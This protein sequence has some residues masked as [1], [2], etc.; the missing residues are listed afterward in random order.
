MLT[1]VQLVIGLTILL[2]GGDCLVRGS[3]RIASAFGMSQLL[4]GMTIVSLGTS[5][6]E[7]AVCLDAVLHGTSEIALGNIVGSNISNIL[8]ILG[9]T[10]LFYPITVSHRIIRVEVPVM[11]GFSFLFLIL[12]FDGR[13]SMLDGAGLVFCMLLF[14]AAQIRSEIR[15]QK[16]SNDE[17]SDAKVDTA[18]KSWKA[19]ASSLS[20]MLAGIVMLWLGADWM[21][22]A[23][24]DI[25][26]AW[27][28]SEL[29]IG[30]TI[31]AIGSSAP[32]LITTVSAVKQG[33]AEMAL[34]NVLGSNIANL[35]TVGGLS[36]I[37]GGGIGVPSSLFQLDLPVMLAAAVLCLP[38]LGLGRRVSRAEGA[39]F[40]T[41][42]CGFTI[43]LFVRA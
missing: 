15:R 2:I 39:V 8:L 27:G 13:L 11:I 10:A 9:L 4:I 33:H 5:A 35:L 3:S 37:C 28:V 34:G 17:E 26:R 24:V 23:A 20:L 30:L 12:V 6:P 29:V 36:A 7:L 18:K 16:N 32:E 40:F 14:L 21:V 25:A 1:A 43:A 38:V 31:V 41:M 42:F 22:A 19:I